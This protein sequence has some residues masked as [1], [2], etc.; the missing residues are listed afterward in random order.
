MANPEVDGRRVFLKKLLGGTA[1]A[2]AGVLL[3]YKQPASAKPSAAR[4]QD[5]EAHEQQY[6]F[7][8]DIDRCI[9]CGNCVSA[10]S[11][12]NKVPQGQF[13]TWVERYVVTQEGVHIDSPKGGMEGFPELDE[14]LEKQAINSF[15]VPKLCNQCEDAPCVQVCP[16]G[17]TYRSDD[18]FVL[19]D[20]EHCMACSYCIQAC[21]YGARFMNKETHMA[22]KCTW[23]Y[24][25]VKNDKLP[26][27]VT[28]CPTHARSFG[29]LNDSAS[30]VAQVVQS[31][32]WDTLKSDLHTGCQVLYSGLPREVV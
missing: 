27:C 6:A 15:F 13:R 9:G 31:D 24:H 1:A 2:S 3:V 29:D 8:V 21:P 20:P 32:H 11:T 30:Q 17:A 12:E 7:V 5:G 16:V 10:C 19:V 18:G 23:C 14:T 25:R 4:K 26:A 22:D 28:V